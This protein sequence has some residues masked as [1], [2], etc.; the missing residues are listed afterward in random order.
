VPVGGGNFLLAAHSSSVPPRIC[1]TDAFAQ[2]CFHTHAEMTFTYLYIQILLQRDDF[3]LSKIIHR[4]Q[5]KER[6]CYKGMHLHE[7]L[8][9]MGIFAQTYNFLIFDRGHA[10]GAKKFSQHMQNHGFT[11]AF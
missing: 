11:A 5:N 3:T 7:E 8:L 2:G 1:S 10:Y 4:C 6:R 9:P